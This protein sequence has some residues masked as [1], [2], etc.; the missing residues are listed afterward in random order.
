[1]LANVES[2]TKNISFL[3]L[4]SNYLLKLY[5]IKSLQCKNKAF[6]NIE[7]QNH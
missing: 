4:G 1:M 5:Y 2:Y 7:V 6:K 3:Y